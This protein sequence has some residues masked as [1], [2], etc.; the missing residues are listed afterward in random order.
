MTH[1][2]GVEPFG[3]DVCPS[4]SDLRWT[5]RMSRAEPR[6]RGLLPPPSDMETVESW[7]RTARKA[8][9]RRDANPYLEHLSLKEAQSFVDAWYRGWDR[10]GSTEDDDTP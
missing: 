4:G 5:Q 3:S 10:A 9:E 6:A 7:G 2:V 1:A 8:G